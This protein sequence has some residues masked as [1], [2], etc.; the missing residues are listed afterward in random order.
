MKR[1]TL[2]IVSILLIGVGLYFFVFE[3]SQAP[4]PQNAVNLTV[5]TQDTQ[6]HDSQFDISVKYPFINN[7]VIDSQVKDYIDGEIS[8]VKTN[9]PNIPELANVKNSLTIS[10]QSAISDRIISY[11]FN[12]DKYTRGDAHDFTYITTF[13]FDRTNN[14]P[15]NL[16]DLFLPGSNYLNAISDLSYNQI[17]SQVQKN[18]EGETD[19]PLTTYQDMI[20]TGTEPTADN[21]KMFFVSKNGLEFSFE[22]GQVIPRVE[23]QAKV[24][25]S[26]DSLGQYLKP[27]YKNLSFGQ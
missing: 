17:L 12:I 20:R 8:D 9:Q 23:G 24:D 15:L 13:S 26:Y 14:Q 22:D 19:F 27:E 4:S 25:I 2:I 16:S 7:Q 11:K 10:F 1:A 5:Q 21:F 3:K 6:Q 18:H